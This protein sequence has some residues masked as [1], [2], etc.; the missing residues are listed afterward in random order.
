[1][2]ESVQRP[3]DVKAGWGESQMKGSPGHKT[4]NKKEQIYINQICHCLCYTW[5]IHN[6]L[7]QNFQSIF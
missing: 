6:N 4:T 3:R 5:Y 2:L 1:M 7:V